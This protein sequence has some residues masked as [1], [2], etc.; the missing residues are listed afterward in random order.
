MML[1]YMMGAFLRVAGL[2]MGELLF[3]VIP[4]ELKR[5]EESLKYTPTS[6]NWED[7]WQYQGERNAIPECLER[8]KEREEIRQLVFSEERNNNYMTG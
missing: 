7:F 6:E 3:T 5:M 8:A 2:M 1:G 4:R